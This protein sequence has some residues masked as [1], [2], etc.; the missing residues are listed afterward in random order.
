MSQSFVRKK[1]IPLLDL[2]AQSETISG[3]LFSA[4]KSVLSSQQFIL[5]PEVKQFEAELATYCQSEFAIGCASGSDAL[6]LALMALGIGAGDEVITTPYSF[7]ATVSSIVRVGAKPVFI[8]IDE[9]TF[10]L[11][12]QLFE[13]SISSRTRAIIPIHLFGQCADMAAIHQHSQSSGIAVVEDA[14]QS[15]G[16]KLNQALAG[17]MG[18]LGTF[19]FYP[20][21]NLGGAGDGGMITTGDPLLAEKLF[22]LRSHGAKRKYFHEEVGIN[23]R[24]DSLQA[25]ILRVKLK[26]LDE[27]IS[28]RRAN[29]SAY[30]DLFQQTD[31]LSRNLIQ[32]PGEIPGA[33]HVYNQFV[34]RAKR[35]DDLREHL[36]HSGIGSEIYYP[37]PLH[38]QPCFHYLGYKAGDMPVSEQAAK[39]SLAIPIYPELGL[40]DQEYIVQKIYDF[41]QSE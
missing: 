24:L 29:A 7:F 2:A 36:N 35:R 3:D 20:S 26:H 33:F 30:R 1:T 25:A 17:S 19:S 12:T 16:A 27:W 37:L 15:I 40:G 22:S 21:K 5:G 6:L 28:L 18:T 31:L 38:L 32:L 11:D 41:Y 39:E 13:K 23:S 8:D 9:N 14:A 10:N 34:I 4:I